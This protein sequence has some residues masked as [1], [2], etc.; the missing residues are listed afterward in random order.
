MKQYNP[1]KIG[2]KKHRTAHSFYLALKEQAKTGL[3][4]IE[5]DWYRARQREFEPEIYKAEMREAER[6]NAITS[7]RK[8][9]IEDLKI[10]LAEKL[11]IP[12]ASTP[13]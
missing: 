7:A 11:T 3:T 4:A 6:R 1:I 2:L 12:T 10:I 5:W 9:S 13:E 8:L